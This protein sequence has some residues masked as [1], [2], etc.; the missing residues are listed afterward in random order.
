MVRDRTCSNS[1]VLIRKGGNKE[2]LMDNNL[3]CLAKWTTRNVSK[4]LAFTQTAI[5]LS[6]ENWRQPYYEHHKKRTTLKG[7]TKNAKAVKTCE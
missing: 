6:I 3:R 1:R 5:R 2:L 7:V 4:N